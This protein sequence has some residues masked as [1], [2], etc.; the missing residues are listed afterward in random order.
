MGTPSGTVTFND[1]TTVLGMASLS[2]GRATFTSSTLMTGMHSITAVY[3]GDT[4]FMGSTSAVLVQTVQQSASQNQAYVTQLYVS[5]LKRQPDAA[6]LAFWTMQLNQNLATN[7]QVALAFTTSQE[8][9]MLEVQEVYQKYLHRSADPVG[10]SG[11]TQYLVH[12]HTLEQLQAEI[13]AS[14]EYLQNRLGGNTDNFLATVI[15]DTFNRSVTQAD[16]NMFGDDFDDYGDRRTTAE[17]IFAT[18]EYRQDLVQSYYQTYL[19]RSA[20]PGG[21]K[22]SVAALGN[23]VTD[24]MLIAVIV[25]SPEFL[26]TQV[27]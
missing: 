3:S 22:A 1:G 23:G 9:R 12:G 27:R 26:A 16:H 2:G 21:L 11:W 20:D 14:Q 5:V 8:F 18:A 6:G 24:E 25:S 4:V 7:E 13:V 17:N 10:L 19:H 15:M